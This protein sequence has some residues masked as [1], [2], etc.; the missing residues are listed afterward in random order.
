MLFALKTTAIAYFTSP[1]KVKAVDY[2][3]QIG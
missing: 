2:A 1:T 3:L